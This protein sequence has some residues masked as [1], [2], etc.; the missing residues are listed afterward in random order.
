MK[1]IQVK[2]FRL[3]ALNMSKSKDLD[4]IGEKTSFIIKEIRVFPN[5][6]ENYSFIFQ[7]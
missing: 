4:H 5:L 3:N 2:K 7:T 1:P 6:N